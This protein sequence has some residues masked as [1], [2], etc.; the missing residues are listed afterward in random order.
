MTGVGD[1]TLSQVVSPTLTTV[2]HY[3]RESGL[4]AAKILVDAMNGGTTIAREVRMGYEVR[5]RR[6]TR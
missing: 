6:S 3:Y 4:E 5:R 1:G 2:H